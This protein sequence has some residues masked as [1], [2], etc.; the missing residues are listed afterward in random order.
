M[1]RVGIVLDVN[2]IP[3]Y[4]NWPTGFSGYVCGT[5][6]SNDASCYVN[7]DADSQRN[8]IDT[9]PRTFA[10]CCDGPIVNITSPVT[11]LND[12][13]AGVNCLAYCPVDFIRTLEPGFGDYWNCLTEETE[14]SGPKF[15]DTI[16]GKVTCGWVGTSEHDKCM[17]SL[18]VESQ[19]SATATS[20]ESVVHFGSNSTT[21]TREAPTCP[22][23]RT[24]QSITS[25]TGP[26]ETSTSHSLAAS[27]TGGTI[28]IRKVV[29]LL[30]VL[31]IATHI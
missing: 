23:Q 18:A 14:G 26:A 11:D 16:N 25:T 9:Q 5:I 27:T 17:I 21:T 20:T 4:P 19:Y 3:R 30:A 31:A 8:I 15:D 22:P 10:S 28:S 7:G 12:P 1:S 24:A 13:S 6:P 2:Y 29:S